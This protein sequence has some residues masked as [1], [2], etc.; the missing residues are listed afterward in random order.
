MRLAIASEL[1]ELDCV[2]EGV[3]CTAVAIPFLSTAQT[4]D[5]RRP[6]SHRKRRMSA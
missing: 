5:S 1:G 6:T 3:G 2:V 4:L